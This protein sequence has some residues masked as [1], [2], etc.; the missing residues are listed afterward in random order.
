VW[1]Y[2]ARLPEIAGPVLA[3]V[4]VFGLARLLSR[5]AL[6]DLSSAALVLFVVHTVLRSFGWLGSAGYARYFVCVSPAIAIITLTGWNDAARLLEGVSR[7]AARSI[8]VL[9]LAVS[10]VSA[11]LYVDLAGFYD[12]DSRAVTD[13]H[14]WWLE[15]PRPVSRLIWSQAYMCI[16]MTCDPMAT[17]ALTGDRAHNLELLR[18]APAGTLAFWDADTGPSWFRLFEGDFV[19]AGYERL[20]SRDYALDGWLEESRWLGWA[21]RPQRMS[22]FYKSH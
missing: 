8:A 15:H 5:R 22:L 7:L 12:R 19:A 1:T 11:V 3:F 6:G 14:G 2:I 9:V 16:V 20:V 13:L 21:P 18:G 10:A 17:P 4:F